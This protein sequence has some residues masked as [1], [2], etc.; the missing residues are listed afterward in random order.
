MLLGKAYYHRCR[1]L[2]SSSHSVSHPEGKRGRCLTICGLFWSVDTDLAPCHTGDDL[3]DLRKVDGNIATCG[4]ERVDGSPKYFWTRA[5]ASAQ[6]I[7]GSARHGPHRAE[8]LSFPYTTPRQE[9]GKCG[10]SN[11]LKGGT[12]LNNI[13]RFTLNSSQFVAE[14]GSVCRTK[15]SLLEYGL[16]TKLRF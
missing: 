7:R 2:S 3:S 8:P 11:N 1:Q 5:Q 9:R 16:R 4:V 13:S 10:R 6:T 12:V 15:R 14:D